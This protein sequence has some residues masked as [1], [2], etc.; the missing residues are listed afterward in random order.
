MDELNEDKGEGWSWDEC[1]MFEYGKY[2]RVLIDTGPGTGTST[3]HEASILV[4][5]HRRTIETSV[6]VPSVLSC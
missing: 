2:A 3:G 1:S 6:K 4:E 5:P